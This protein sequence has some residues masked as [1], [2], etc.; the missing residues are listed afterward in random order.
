[1]F[2]LPFLMILVYIV[3]LG[4]ILFLINHWVSKFIEVRKE[5]NNLL[6]KII[7]KMDVK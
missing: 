3:I 2:L 6:E 1:M 5:Q 4:G 7:D